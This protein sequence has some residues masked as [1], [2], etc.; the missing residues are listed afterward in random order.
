MYAAEQLFKS[1]TSKE[2]YHTLY[3]I[4]DNDYYVQDFSSSNTLNDL[5]YVIEM[6][7]LIYIAS[8]ERVLLTQRGEKVLQH[9]TALLI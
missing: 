9:L 4:M 1:M 5:L 6:Y 3:G 2:L 7:N 8:D